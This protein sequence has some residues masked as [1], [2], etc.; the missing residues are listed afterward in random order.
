MIAARL[1]SISACVM[2]AYVI[3]HLLNHALALVSLQAGASLLRL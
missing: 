2:L 3:T 1:R